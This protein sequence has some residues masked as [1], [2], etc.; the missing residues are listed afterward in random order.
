MSETTR[1]YRILAPT[2]YQWHFNSPKHSQNVIEKRD[3]VPLNY[4]S[5]KIEGFTVLN[6]FPLRRFDLVHAYNRIPLSRLPF[7]IGF[8]SHMPRGFGME[9]T[10]Y[11]RWLTSML[12]SDRCRGIVAISHWAKRTFEAMHAGTRNADVLMQKLA[13]RYPNM[14]VPEI[15]DPVDSDA[16]TVLLSFVGNHFARKG[17]LVALRI[18]EKARERGL[19]IHVE[20]ASKL[21]MGGAIWTDPVREDFYAPYLKLLELPNVTFH[22]GMPNAEVIKLLRR[23]HLSLLPTFS[24]T[25]GYS[26]I[27]SMMN[28]APV[29]ATRLQALQEFVIDGHSGIQVSIPCNP[30]GDWRHTQG[31][32]RSSTAFETL[33][34]DGVEDLAEQTLAAIEPFLNDRPRL[35]R[36]RAQARATARELF[37]SRRA[38]P[39]WDEAYDRAIARPQPM[40]SFSQAG[41]H[42][43]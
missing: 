7:I 29:I 2:R 34:R 13:V 42:H 26:A 32:D 11:F 24:D 37:D 33:F 15:E 5:S 4:V 12:L 27:E 22:H 31:S 40:A 35:K 18:A 17:G 6:P 23:T 43:S 14:V 41:S 19:P 25:F 21:Q 16:E 10:T 28:F 30:D 36:L 39:W 38:S 9:Q 1:A 3:F 8:E 20:I